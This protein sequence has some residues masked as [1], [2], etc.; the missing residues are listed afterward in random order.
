[1]L[2]AVSIHLALRYII[3]LICKCFFFRNGVVRGCWILIGRKLASFSIRLS[4]RMP[5]NRPKLWILIFFQSVSNNFSKLFIILV[6]IIFVFQPANIRAA[7][8]C[9]VSSNQT[10]TGHLRGIRFLPEAHYKKSH[11]TESCSDCVYPQSRTP[12]R[13]TC[14]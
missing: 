12:H 14:C 2:N 6:T 5:N 4:Q 13:K 9:V 7:F 1:M 3:Q 8:S 11:G 10:S